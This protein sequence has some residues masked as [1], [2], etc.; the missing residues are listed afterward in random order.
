MKNKILIDLP[1]EVLKS[2]G[3]SAIDAE[4]KRKNFIEFLLIEIS[5]DENLL[6][7]FV[8][9]SVKYNSVKIENKNKKVDY[10]AKY[11]KCINVI[12][13][14]DAGIIGMYDL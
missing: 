4:K 3:K 2:L 12:R 7:K 1:E 13:R 8:E 11:D 6:K 5:K 9:M 14:F 10:K